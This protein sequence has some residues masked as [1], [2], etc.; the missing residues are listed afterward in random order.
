MQILEKGSAHWRWWKREEGRE[1]GGDIHTP[2]LTT[3]EVPRNRLVFPLADKNLLN[4]EIRARGAASYL[5]GWAIFNAKLP[6]RNSLW[7]QQGVPRG[8]GSMTGC[9]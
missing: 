3:G 9:W 1:G 8:R 4:E 2:L 5:A 7:G 6:S